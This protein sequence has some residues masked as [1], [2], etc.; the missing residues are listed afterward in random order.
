[1]PSSL[2][3]P[4][5][6]A[7][8][9]WSHSP[10]YSMFV[11]V[12]LHLLTA[13]YFLWSQVASR[14]QRHLIFRVTRAA[15]LG[16]GT[17]RDEGDKSPGT[18]DR[19]SG[20]GDVSSQRE[21]MNTRFKDA[22]TPAVN[23][24]KRK[25]DPTAYTVG[26]ICALRI[27]HFA[28]RPLFDEEHVGPEALTG[29]IDFEYTLGRVGE[30]NV[31]IVVMPEACSNAASIAAQHLSYSFPNIQFGLMVG[32]G[33]G[34]P[35]QKHDIRLGDIVGVPRGDKHGVL[36]YDM[37]KT[38][39]DGSLHITGFLNPPPIFLRNAVDRL[40]F[41][42]EIPGQQLQLSINNILSRNP[43]LQTF[44]LPHASADRLYQAEVTHPP[45]TASCETSCGNEPMKLVLRHERVPFENDPAVH[46]GVIASASQVVRNAF[47]RDKLAGK[48]I[49]C[50]EMEAAGLI[51]HF[52]CLVI[53]S[54]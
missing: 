5:L 24:R 53:R 54:I 1:M 2:P 10:A 19:I 51:S 30:H 13:T 29:I 4:I 18:G 43:R 17:S 9:A 7:D 41:Q 6:A 26:W 38:M 15:G 22:P 49:L 25:L 8:L 12:L 47:I 45:S 23:T 42:Y 16:G 44:K 34:A 21:A 50:F 3:R 28:A 37:G 27:E 35:S 11:R 46:Y 40:Q 33:G 48:N 32:I 31:V 20:H 36:Q 39:Q 52:P 14:L